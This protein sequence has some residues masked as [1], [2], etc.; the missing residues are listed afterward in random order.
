[1]KYKFIME[2]WRKF[3]T[4][5]GPETIDPIQGAEYPLVKRAH[6]ALE[7]GDIQ[8]FEDALQWAKSTATGQGAI[9]AT[10]LA[11][12]AALKLVSIGKAAAARKAVDSGA[13]TLREVPIVEKIFN[14]HPLLASYKEM[15]AKWAMWAYA[16]SGSVLAAEALF[17]FFLVVYPTKKIYDMIAMLRNKPGSTTTIIHW[18]KGLFVE[19]SNNEDMIKKTFERWKTLIN[20]K[21]EEQVFKEM[22]EFKKLLDDLKK[23]EKKK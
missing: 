8:N 7:D 22:K 3:L 1:M 17:N 20:E 19:S 9:S 18:V 21:K 10:I 6:Q 23:V 15:L 5:L 2:N 13:I 11:A 4:E 12:I 16:K 14:L